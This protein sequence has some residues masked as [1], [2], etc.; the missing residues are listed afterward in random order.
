MT[1]G[2]YQILPAF[3]KLMMNLKKSKREFAVVFHARK[4]DHHEDLIGEL[5]LFFNGEHPFYNGKNGTPLVKFDGSK[6]CKNF[7]LTNKNTCVLYR[8]GK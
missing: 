8:F 4:E 3:Y 5:N 7:R 6:N 2:K 1:S